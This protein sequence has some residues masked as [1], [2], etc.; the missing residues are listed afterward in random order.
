MVLVLLT[1][2]EMVVDVIAEEKQK[3]KIVRIAIDIEMK[4]K[5]V[6]T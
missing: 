1:I 3:K 6:Q 4:M 5:K 2:A